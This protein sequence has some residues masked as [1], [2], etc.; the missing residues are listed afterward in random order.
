MPAAP[1]RAP[2]GPPKQR[3][4]LSGD[5]RCDLAAC[6]RGAAGQQVP[7]VII[8]APTRARN[9]GPTV[10][11][12]AREKS[13]SLR[14]APVTRLSG[15]SVPVP[16]GPPLGA[17]DSGGQGRAGQPGGESSTDHVGRCGAR[18]GERSH[19]R[20]SAVGRQ[21]S[22]PT[23]R[24]GEAR[25]MSPGGRDFVGT[26]WGP[27]PASVKRDSGRPI[28]QGTRRL[29]RRPRGSVRRRRARHRWRP[30][31]RRNHLHHYKGAERA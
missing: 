5:G 22:R 17:L 13:G 24:R 31:S 15:R 2:L 25:T 4:A 7:G 16:I 9:L 11:A 14:R 27:T 29:V 6:V 20:A 23:Q 1:D 21:S 26:R 8:A 10:S 3:S 19:V 18:V 28:P 12:T 30:V